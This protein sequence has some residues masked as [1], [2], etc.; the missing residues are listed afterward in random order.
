MASHGA[1]GGPEEQRLNQPS[2]QLPARSH[3]CSVLKNPWQWDE[4][5]IDGLGHIGLVIPI[6][7][8]IRDT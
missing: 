3:P 1:R 6:L 5:T 2:G 7:Q 8:A 4:E